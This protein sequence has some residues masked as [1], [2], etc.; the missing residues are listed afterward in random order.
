MTLLAFACLA[1][2]QSPSIDAGF[3]RARDL[4]AL[5]RKIFFDPSLSATGR[6]SCASCHDP[7]HA[8][9]PSTALPGRRAAPSLRYLQ[10]VPQFTEHS[11]DPDAPDLGSLDNGPTGG[12]TWDGR[13]DRARDQARLPLLS[14]DE[15]AN[16]DP[17]DVV[18]KALRAPYGPELRRL[19]GPRLFDTMLEALE[20]FE[21]DDREFYPYSS[22]YDAFL[23]GR[24]Q[25]NDRES[26]GLKLFTDPAK[27]SCAR[28]HIATRGPDGTPP[29]FTDYALAAL[30]LPRNREIPANAD[31]RFFDLGLCG[32][33]RHD[34]SGHPEYCGRFMTPTLRNVALRKAFFHNGVVH[35][36]KDAVA[37]YVERDTNP[38]KWYPGGTKFDDLPEPYRA[39][40]E[41]DPPF[42]RAP[43][44]QPALTPEEIDDVVAF[45]ETLT[46]GYLPARP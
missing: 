2:A 29:Q 14:P 16:R 5:G 38:A 9:G 45:L 6:I 4:S 1:L 15:M 33:D 43:G 13:V 30:G 22:K 8:Y 21:Q 32:P 12:L 23:A 41:T 36:L 37:F 44:A 10:A 42:G 26:R 19:A 17:D 24:A 11:F 46:D 20:A 34:L 39:N 40:V 35:T 27:G 7:R 3:H 28:C 31:P 18:S 25:L